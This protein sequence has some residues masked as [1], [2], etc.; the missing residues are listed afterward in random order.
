[1]ISNVVIRCIIYYKQNKS[2]REFEVFLHERD[3]Q[4]F[5]KV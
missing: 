3:I 4:Y 1:M 5:V 2:I